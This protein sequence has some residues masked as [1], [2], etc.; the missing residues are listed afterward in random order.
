MLKYFRECQTKFKQANQISSALKISQAIHIEW[1]NYDR[2]T[3]T[4]TVVFMKA[5]KW[6]MKRVNVR[7]KKIR[8]QSMIKDKFF[9]L[10]Y[11]LTSKLIKRV[12]QKQSCLWWN[13]RYMY[14]TTQN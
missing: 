10:Q 3:E 2:N 12:R 5:R 4:S 11:R 9:K 7:L 14:F 8:K 1:G 6:L 13:F